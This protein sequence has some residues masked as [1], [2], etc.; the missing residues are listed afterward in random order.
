MHLETTLTFHKQV[1]REESHCGFRKPEGYR[2]APDH[3]EANAQ[4]DH[5]HLLWWRWFQMRLLLPS[6][7]SI[8]L[9]CG[10]PTPESVVNAWKGKHQSNATFP[11]SP[12]SMSVFFPDPTTSHPTFLPHPIHECTWGA[13]LGPENFFLPAFQQQQKVDALLSLTLHLVNE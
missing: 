4:Q 9:V 10:Q 8:W 12:W 11:S 7:E 6:T 13:E 2:T 3:D 1:W 5:H